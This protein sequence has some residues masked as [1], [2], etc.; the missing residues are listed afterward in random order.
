MIDARNDAKYELAVEVLGSFGGAQLPVT[1]ASMLP[2]LW[3]GDILEVRR[4]SPARIFAGDVVVF[5]RQGRLLAH[6]VV[7]KLGTSDGGVLVTRGDRLEQ[8]DPPV[9]AEELLG[10]VTWVQRG[11]RRLGPRL[12]LWGRATSWVL[13]RSEFCTRALLRLRG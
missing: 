9:S 12:T 6:R 5:R 2:A 8:T 13:R 7:E 3:P 4:E 1:G 10:C 11:H